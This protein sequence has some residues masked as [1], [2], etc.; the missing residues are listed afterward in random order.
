MKK[1]AYLT[2]RV[3]RQT[4]SF[5]VFAAAVFLYFGNEIG[6]LM[7]GDTFAGRILRILAPAVPFIYLEIIL[8]GILKGMGRHSF[9][10]LNYLVEYTIR[11]SVLL[12]CVPLFGFYGIVM[13]YLASNIICNTSRILK[14]IS[15]TGI[16]F[17]FSDNIII[18]VIS[19]LCSMQTVS[20]LEKPLHL[21]RVS[22]AVE[23][24]IFT[25]TAGFMYLGLQKLIHKIADGSE[26]I[27]VNRVDH[28]L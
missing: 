24:V 8:E 9:S 2:N 10:S 18:P 26:E 3:L 1:T 6:L 15:I 27:S 11:I 4:F 22:I 16:C 17:S 14:I 28:K 13:S 19:A 20:L 21:E 7:S 5:S 23:P 25:I 12:I